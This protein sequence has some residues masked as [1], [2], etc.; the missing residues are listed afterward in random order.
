MSPFASKDSKPINPVDVT[1]YSGGEAAQALLAGLAQVQSEAAQ[2]ASRRA[3]AWMELPQAMSTCHTL[4][5]VAETQAR[6]VQAFW[7]DWLRASQRMATTWSKTM[8]VPLQAV[9]EAMPAGRAP[10]AAPEH[11][12]FA[13]WEWWR[14]DMKAIVPRRN[15]TATAPANRSDTH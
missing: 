2:L 6:F 11:D 8:A 9:A 14:T 7:T 10:S 12:S 1:A 3:R 4:P 13:V 15:E 5:E